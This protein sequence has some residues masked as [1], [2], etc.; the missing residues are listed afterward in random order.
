MLLRIYTLIPDIH[1]E[2]L[3]DIH[4]DLYAPIPDMLLKIYTPIP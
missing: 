3:A 2:C 1:P 4:P